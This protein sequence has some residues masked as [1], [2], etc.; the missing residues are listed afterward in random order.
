MKPMG[1]RWMPIMHF[2]LCHL[3]EEKC[4]VRKKRRNRK[5]EPWK[6]HL[7]MASWWEQIAAIPSFDD[8][9]QA[10]SIF[11]KCNQQYITW[12][13]ILLIII[14][15]WW[16]MYVW[17]YI[18]REIRHS[19]RAMLCGGHHYKVTAPSSY[20]S[21]HINTKPLSIKITSGLLTPSGLLLI[22]NIKNLRSCFE[23]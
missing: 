5:G 1:K 23:L 4:L 19:S 2:F 12:N 18:L 15:N 20:L 13:C 11:L 14:Y 21:S 10:A 6:K 17:N 7:L 16:E 3:K 8:A 22:L 9:L